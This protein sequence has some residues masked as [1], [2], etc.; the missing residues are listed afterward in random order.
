MT[1]KVANAA[2]RPVVY[3]ELDATDPSAP[4]TSGPDTFVDLLIGTA[5][6]RTSAAR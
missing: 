2:Q 4:Y 6:A 1:D 5:G 3:Y